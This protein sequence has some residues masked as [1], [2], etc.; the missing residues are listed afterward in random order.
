[1]L[2]QS[3]LIVKNEKGIAHEWTHSPNV[4]GGGGGVVKSNVFS[5]TVE[6]IEVE[7][8]RL[9]ANR[10]VVPTTLLSTVCM[11]SATDSVRR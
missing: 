2:T 10:G 9:P 8:S 4:G 5:E 11:A 3:M 6:S 1:M 7:R